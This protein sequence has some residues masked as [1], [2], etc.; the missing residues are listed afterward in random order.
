MTDAGQSVAFLGLGQMG[1]PMATNL[2]KAG[3]SV[4]GYDPRPERVAQLV[5]MG[6][7]GA[8]SAA[9]AAAAADTVIAIPF[10]G[11]Q[12]RAALLGDRGAVESLA[13]G[14]LVIVM[15][16]IGR[17]SIQDLAADVAG[18]GFLLVDA[19]VTGGAHG[20]RAGT[21]T[22]IASG[23]PD[24][25]DRAAPIFEPMSGAV[26]RV[27]SEPGAGQFVKLL[28]QLLVGVHVV[29][30]AETLAMGAAAGVDLEQAYEVLCHGFGRSD[31]FV[32]RAR[33]VLDGKLETGGSVAIF[34]K[35]MALV[36]QAANSLGVPVFA[37]ASAQQFVELGA[38]LGHTAEDDATLIQ[39][40]V[41]LA[42]R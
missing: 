33:A 36:V 3:V 24:A 8:G 13:P 29:A 17:A 34:L 30:T 10:D 18:R 15:A 16:T 9:E 23:A 37:A 1:L 21:L 14:G 40:L 20:A 31:V 11:A 4:H 7:A 6:G 5:E 12:C 22:I 2:V 32:H 19:P 39:M 27:G 42:R 26:Y 25:L 41:D 38:A 28:N 35:D